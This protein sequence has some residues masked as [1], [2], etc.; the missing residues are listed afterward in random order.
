[1]NKRYL[2]II[3]L[4]SL[5]LFFS[6]L[7]KDKTQ[8]VLKEY[9]LVWS[10]EFNGSDLNKDNWSFV[11]WDA[12]KVNNE[13]QRYVE[14]KANYK[15]KNGK[16]SIT[17]TKTGPNKSGG[18]S[19][20]RLISKT[21]QEF[22]YGRIEFRAKMPSGRGTWP[23]LWM[24][25]SNI[26]EVGWPMCGEID[27]MEYVGFQPD[28]THSNIHTKYQSVDTDFHAIIP[29][30]TAE[31]EFHNYGI[32]WSQDSINFYIDS[33]TNITNTYSPINKD[34]DNWPFNHS[35]YL[36]MNFAVGGN[37]GGT[38]GVDGAIWPQSMIVD[39]VR[40]YQLK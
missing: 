40:V 33:I 1:M 25:G 27:I 31:E 8:T 13:W 30:E 26:D 38:E 24:L 6:C 35:F 21:K 19:S 23:A 2:L 17:A 10:D 22:K 15:I 32:I 37:W 20:T 16:I 9:K 12:A 11:L 28:L 39:Y 7:D 4:I 14:D 5:S 18:Y 36:I 34:S 3:N 29:L